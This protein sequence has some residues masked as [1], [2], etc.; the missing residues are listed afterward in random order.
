MCIC[1]EEDCVCKEE[2]FFQESYTISE[3]QDTLAEIGIADMTSEKQ[4]NPATHLF[5]GNYNTYSHSVYQIHNGFTVTLNLIH[6]TRITRIK[7]F[8]RRSCCLDRIVGFSVYIKKYKEE[9]EIICGRM[10]EV[11]QEYE[12]N[13]KGTGYKVELRKVEVVDR[14]NIAEVEIYG[15]QG[16][17][18][19]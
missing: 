15:Q 11:K 9:G 6:V 13:C 12:F 18:E 16:K 8:N 2:D 19:F 17:L 5:D 14:V 4:D 7:V 3:E 10:E 1:K